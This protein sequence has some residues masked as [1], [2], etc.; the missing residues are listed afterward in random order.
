MFNP[1]RLLLILLF[2]LT[3]AWGVYEL[4]RDNSDL[5]LRAPPP[6][7]G[8]G[9]ALSISPP[10]TTPPALEA[11]AETLQRP[12]FNADR[13]PF[14]ATGPEE[15]EKPVLRA[16]PRPEVRL[17]AIVAQDDAH[18]A[19]FHSG[20]SG[21]TTHLSLGDELEGWKLVGLTDDSATLQQGRERIELEL[22]E[23]EQA[24]QAAAPPKIRRGPRIPPAMRPAP[25]K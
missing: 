25:Q 14:A 9:G 7:Q 19:L 2:G 12:L 13:Q 8:A 1:L 22:R 21:E 16:S 6:G 10:E 15:P 24:P 3:L 23:F 20:R 11:F 17:T 4:R 18:S 5:A